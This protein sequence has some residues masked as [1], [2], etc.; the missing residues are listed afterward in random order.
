MLSYEKIKMPPSAV[1]PA[2]RRGPEAAA[3]RLAW[4]GFLLLVTLALGLPAPSSAASWSAAEM[5]RSSR[6]L[7]LSPGQSQVFSIVFKN[8]GTATWKADGRN[9]VSIYTYGPKYRKSQFSDASWMSQIQPARLIDAEV[10][11]GQLGRISFAL[12][13]PLEAGA[14]QETFALAAEDLSWVSGGIFT[15]NIKVSSAAAATA[16]AALSVG[17]RLPA[18]GYK[19]LKLIS[20]GDR[21]SLKAGETRDFRVAFKNI[22]RLPWSTGGT[23]ALSLRADAGNAYSFRHSSWAAT[24]IV[25]RPSSDIKPGE[26]GFFNF[27]VSAPSSSGLYNA[28]F[29]LAA[30]ENPVEGGD[31]V[32]PIEVTQGLVSSS[33]PSGYDA[34]LSNDGPRG[35]DIRIGL[36]SPDNPTETVTLTAN[37]SYRLMD[38]DGN[39]V[40]VLSGLT[41]VTFDLASRSYSVV[42]GSFSRQMFK[43]LYFEPVDASTIFEITSIVSRPTWDPSINFNKFRGKIE[44]FYVLTTGNLWVV[45]ELPMEDYLR[46]LAETSN[47]SPYEYQKALVTAARTY[48]LYVTAM[49]GKHQKEFFDL[50]TTG[51]DQVYKGYASELVRPNVVRAVED[52]RGTVVT[53]NGEIV[54]TPYFSRSDGRTRAWTEVWSSKVHPWLVSRPCIY[55]Q[56][57]TMLGHGVG[58][59]ASDSIGRANAGESWTD[60]LKYYYTGVELKRLY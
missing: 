19:A 51:N 34:D 44:I 12:Y 52:T 6:E 14:Y 8:T 55:D 32:L 42:N 56:G 37:G 43:Y 53:Y 20:S 38:S 47:G 59:S 26:L 15:V 58:L 11:P 9:F 4:A 29:V 30:G 36:Y 27:S 3:S 31:L 2:G 50:D 48:A 13:A 25:T 1:P 33:I 17:A 60:I 40:T 54:V 57:K 18:P 41:S 7:T 46:G 24:D 22:G 39:A 45:E 16:N 49:G 5:L 23:S 28:R 21:L 10:K 35:P